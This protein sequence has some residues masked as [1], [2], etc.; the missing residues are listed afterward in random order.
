MKPFTTVTGPAAP[1]PLDDVDTDQIIPSPYLKDLHADLG[2]G[3]LAYMRRRPE[4]SRIEDFV[5]ERP[6]FRAAPILLVGRNFGCGSS[7]E[8]AV[9]ALQA[10]GVRCVI[11]QR[12]AEF[13]V[14]NCL[15]NGVLPIALDADQMRG[16]MAAALACDGQEP[17]TV[18]LQAREVRGPGGLRLAFGLPDAQRDA[19]LAGL[20]DIGL[21]LQQLDLIEAWEQR[22]P[23]PAAA[24]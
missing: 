24:A 23:P 9:W 16:L 11:G 15:K 6:A 3:L 19:L 12:P 20:D 14:D 10:F 4:G 13:F 7:R 8:H 1:L 5:L 21:T 2:A 17:F 22:Q 18:D